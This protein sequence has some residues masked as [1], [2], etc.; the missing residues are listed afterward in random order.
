MMNAREPEEKVNR[1][2]LGMGWAAV[3]A[4]AA[5]G[6]YMRAN[7]PALYGGNEAVHYMYRA[8]HVYI[9][10]AGLLNLAVGSYLSPGAVRWRRGLQ[11][12]GSFLYLVAPAIFIFA[13]FFDPP[14]GGPDK[15][16]T[17]LGVFALI[18]GT[19]L[20]LLARAGVHPAELDAAARPREKI[21]ESAIID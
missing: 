6:A 3:G 20:H 10:F 12:L 19:G 14:R 11:N 4:F 9:L 2:H 1:L 17:V 21:E 8:N 16:A 15:P 18:I 7:F 13:F 5:T